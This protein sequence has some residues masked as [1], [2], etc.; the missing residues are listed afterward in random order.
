MVSDSTGATAEEYL[1]TPTICHPE[2]V[3]VFAREGLA[4]KDPSSLLFFARNF[5]SG[6]ASQ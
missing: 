3:Q 2:A 5:L 4:M 6:F 1:V